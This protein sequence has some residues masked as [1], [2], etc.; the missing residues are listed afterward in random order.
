MS[1][2]RR[3]LVYLVFPV[4]LLAVVGILAVS[5]ID[6][7]GKAAGDILSNNYHTIR[8]ARGIENILHELELKISEPDF[9]QERK[10]NDLFGIDRILLECRRSVTAPEE[11]QTLKD[12]EAML[13]E[14]RARLQIS[15]SKDDIDSLRER[16]E[17]IKKLYHHIDNLIAFNEKAM[18]EYED[19]TTRTAAVL[20]AVLFGTLVAAGL[21]LTVFAAIAARR[22]STPIIEVA[23]RLHRALQDEQR[24]AIGARPNRDEISR[25]RDELDFLL[26]RL[27]RYE[28]RLSHRILDAERQLMFVIDRIDHGLLLMDK[29]LAILAVNRTARALL[30]LNES[31][32][33]LSNLSN[34]NLGDEM[35]AALFPLF[36]SSA[37]SPVSS[38]YVHLRVNNATVPFR[39]KILP[40]DGASSESSGYLVIF[41]DMTEERQ[42]QETREQ[43][44]ATMSHQLKTPITSLSMAVNLLW[45]N[46]RS[47]GFDDTELLEIA[48]TDCAAVSAIVSEL[49]DI[50]RNLEAVMRL[51][52]RPT[53]LRLL[54][55]DTL[56]S[57]HADA[58]A[59]GIEIVRQLGESPIFLDLDDVK[60]PWVISNIVGN[61]LRFTPRSGHITVEIERGVRQIVISISDTGRGM[62]ANQRSRLFI[63]FASLDPHPPPDA[64]GIGLVV[65]KRVIEGHGGVIAVESEPG[66]GTTFRITLPVSPLSEKGSIH[67]TPLCRGDD[68]VF[69][70]EKDDG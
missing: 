44:I 25:L 1:I 19:R 33:M 30:G 18:L 46:R 17:I 14:L 20:T 49:V 6:R 65:A 47:R 32:D 37:P 34:L 28:D 38:P 10:I 26:A 66:R 31:D 36:E 27:S 9:I 48:R 13:G 8:H 42:L 43:F 51:T 29:S 62:D 59:R 68:S 11:K 63:P 50:S 69:I 45:E 39:V 40:F 22:L 56:K 67:L 4:F 12:I 21:V 41:W 57:F 61:A 7:L 3:V 16:L 70:A 60:F 35:T 2:K 52:L 15:T 58:K 53:D 64:F 23:D 55:D 24:T 54:I 5:S